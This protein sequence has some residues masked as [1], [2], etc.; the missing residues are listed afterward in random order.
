MGMDIKKLLSDERA[1]LFL[2]ALLYL[3]IRIP[4]LSYLPFIQDEAVYTVQ[5]S[6]Q[7]A[8][9]SFVPTYLGSGTDWKPPLF[10]WVYAVLVKPLMGLPLP[11]EAVFKLPTLLFGLANMLLLYYL[12]KAMTSN[13]E[14]AFMTALIHTGIFLVV[15]VNTTVL[16]DTFM[17]TLVLAGILCYVKE[18]WGRRRFLAGGAFTFLTFMTKFW[19]ALIIPLM[20][21]AYFASRDRKVLRDRAFLLSLLSIVI[22]YLVFSAFFTFPGTVQ[23]VSFIY[24]IQHRLLAVFSLPQIVSSFGMFFVFSIVWVGI[25]LLGAYKFWRAEPLMTLW[26]ALGVFPIF[27]GVYLLWYYLPVM[28]PVAFFSAR[29]LLDNQG[30]QRLDGF[31]IFFTMLIMIAGLAIGFAYYNELLGDYGGQRTAGELIALKDN[32]VIV[33]N[34]CPAVVAYKILEET[35]TGSEKDFGWILAANATDSIVRSFISDY[36]TSTYPLSSDFGTMFDT[37]N[38]MYR[39]PSNVTRP[40]Y[41]VVCGFPN[42]TVSGTMLSNESYVRV[43][44]TG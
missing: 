44:K 8:H 1:L 30:K 36:N 14:L 27:G 15:N 11:L 17:M 34:Y 20:A 4:L 2:L 6:E 10:F 3:A 5:I 38:T 19:L 41:V 31:C 7:M 21:V 23:D 12:I 25:S 16:M 42:V 29:L 28:V 33:G 13:R 37:T 35:R 26:L 32:T 24:T 43:F 22:A 18:S 40:D 9:F 39:K